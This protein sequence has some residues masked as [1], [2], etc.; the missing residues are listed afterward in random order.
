MS[1]LP[2]AASC[3]A[4]VERPGSVAERRRALRASLEGMVYADWQ[5][6]AA[7][8]RHLWEYCGD[9]HPRAFFCHAV[10]RHPSVWVDIL[11][12]LASRGRWEDLC[13]SSRVHDAECALGHESLA[14]LYLSSLMGSP[15]VRHVRPLLELCA[16]F[17][18][19][20]SLGPSEVRR[21]GELLSLAPQDALLWL[22]ML[23]ASQL[24]HASEPMLRQGSTSVVRLLEKVARAHPSTLRAAVASCPSCTL[25]VAD[26]MRD[27]STL[28][29]ARLS[30]VCERYARLSRLPPLYRVSWHTEMLSRGLD[31]SSTYFG[32]AWEPTS[33]HTLLYSSCV[34]GA[35]VGS[36]YWL[37][38]ALSEAPAACA[39]CLSRYGVDVASALASHRARS[40]WLLRLS[41]RWPLPWELVSLLSRYI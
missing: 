27:P 22:Y 16:R 1:L 6:S 4:S 21:I 19:S 37:S 18:S 23:D 38:R 9:V 17:V 32:P 35:A 20:E 10:Y 5:P 8:V 24:Q 31:V 36:G 25:V 40:L 12:A 28:S 14:P 3:Y 13:A 34:A 29:D 7:V 2:S 30:R 33:V 39:E 41:G 11:R 26:A 15:A